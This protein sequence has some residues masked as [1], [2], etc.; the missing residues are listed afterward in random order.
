MKFNFFQWAGKIL[1]ASVIFGYCSVASLSADTGNGDMD[2]ASHAVVKIQTTFFEY[3]Y[4]NPW[5]QPRLNSAG[6]TGFIIEGN[7]ILTNAHVVSLANTIRVQRPGQRSDFEAEVAFIAHDS[8]LAI[9]TVKDDNFFD[10]SKPLHIGNTPELNTPV[11][12]VGFPIGGDRISITRGIVSRKDVDAYSHSSIDYHLTVQVD[13]AINP[14]NSGGPALQDGKVIGI[15]FQVYTRGENLGYLIPPP[16]VNR[17]LN[18][19]KDGTYDG[20]IEFGTLDMPTVNP[21][22]K[23]YLGLDTPEFGD[24]SGVFVYRVVPDSSAFGHIQPGD[25]LLSLNGYK[26]S[27]MGDV[28]YGGHMVAYTEIVDNMANGTEVEAIVWRKGKKESLRFALK[29]TEVISFQR[30]N[31]DTPPEYYMLGG[32]LFQPMNAD[33]MSAYSGDWGSANRAEIFYRYNYFLR[34]AIYKTTSRDIVLTRRLS[35]PVNLYAS[36]YENRIVESVNGKHV[37]DFAGFVDAI[38]SVLDKEPYLIIEFIDMPLPL[39]LSTKD[40]VQSNEA[41]MKRYGI[42]DGERLSSRG[43]SR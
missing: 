42:P 16:V 2:T 11:V 26:I 30:K 8:D 19:I 41:I 15:A 9:L 40:V 43:G 23:K 3:S 4:K 27:E 32:F 12:V 37:R 36:S 25:I 39:V 29:K 28:D 7:R 14:G 6:G 35:D 24:N 18:D 38:K 1:L 10:G 5:Q 31:Y 22:M 34:H 20:Y 13:A 17:F 21:V 33:L